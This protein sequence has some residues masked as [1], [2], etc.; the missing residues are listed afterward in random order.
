V[1]NLLSIEP[2]IKMVAG[3]LGKETSTGDGDLCWS[4]N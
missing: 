4:A 2:L 1:E 3:E